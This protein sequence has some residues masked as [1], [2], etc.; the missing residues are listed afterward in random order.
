MFKIINFLMN[1]NYF[2]EIILCKLKIRWLAFTIIINEI[3]TVKMVEIV[4][5]ALLERKQVR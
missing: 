3:E 1:F 4:A 2:K 5:V